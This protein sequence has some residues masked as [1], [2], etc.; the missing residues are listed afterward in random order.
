M[1]MKTSLQRFK[2]AIDPKE[3]LIDALTNAKAALKSK[4]AAGL[5]KA[6]HGFIGDTV[7]Q[8]LLEAMI[9]TGTKPVEAAKLVG[10]LKP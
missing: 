2:L 9:Q 4:S 1:T 3:D 5:K 6:L 8:I 7:A 10:R